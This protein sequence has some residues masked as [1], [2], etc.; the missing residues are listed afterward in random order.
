[1]FKAWNPWA[2]VEPESRLLTDFRLSADTY[3]QDLL[4]RYS[5]I[6]D[7]F[8]NA[9]EYFLDPVSYKLKE[10]SWAD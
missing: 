6:L 9:R 8:S 5:Q 2:L 4:E 10:G 7:T 1:M 3:V